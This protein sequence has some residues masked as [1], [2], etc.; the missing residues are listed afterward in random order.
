V[1]A[2]PSSSQSSHYSTAP[3]GVGTGSGSTSGYTSATYIAA[4]QPSNATGTGTG[5][6]TGTSNTGSSTSSTGIPVSSTTFSSTSSHGTDM[7]TAGVWRP[8]DIASVLTAAGQ[9]AGGGASLITSVGAVVADFGTAFKDI[10]GSNGVTGLVQEGVDAAQKINV[11]AHYHGDAP[12][13]VASDTAAHSDTGGTGTGGHAADGSHSST[14]GAI[15][16]T[17]GQSVSGNSSSGS[18]TATAGYQPFNLGTATSTTSTTPS[19][20]FGGSLGSQSREGESE[21]RSTIRYVPPTVDDDEQ[22]TE[23]TEKSDSANESKTD[24][25]QA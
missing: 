17:P 19:S 16:Q 8:G 3:A 9:A 2:A 20:F 6:G 1:T 7:G 22:G 14:S 13:T 23:A 10:V 5:T 12:A 18:P 15:N 21:H 25:E 4:T 24:G 11:M